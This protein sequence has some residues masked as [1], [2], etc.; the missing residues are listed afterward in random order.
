M[1]KNADIYVDILEFIEKH[2][3]CII[4]ISVDNRQFDSFRKLVG[5]I[6]AKRVVVKKESEL[7]K[8]TPEYKVSLI[9]DTLLNLKRN[10]QR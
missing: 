6:D 4:F 1:Y 10:E 9:I 3:N 8:G 7:I 2:G 5:F